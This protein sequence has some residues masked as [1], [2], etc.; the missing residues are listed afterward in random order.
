MSLWVFMFLRVFFSF[1]FSFFFFPDP[2]SW[3]SRRYTK[4]TVRQSE[5]VG[6][7]SP[8]SYN[9]HDNAILGRQLVHFYQV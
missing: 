4:H 1:F 8:S 3:A 7:F 5:S 9:R 2:I 6:H